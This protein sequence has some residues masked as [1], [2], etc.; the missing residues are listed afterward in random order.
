MILIHLLLYGWLAT[1]CWSVLVTV[2]DTQRYTMLFSSIILKCDYSTSAQL[3]DVAVTWRFKSFCMDPLF[4]YYSAAYQAGLALNQDPSNDCNDRQ[5]EVRIVIQKR[6]QNEAVLGMDYRQRKITMRD[7]ADLVINEVMW[8][9]HGVYYCSVEA[10]GDTAGDPDKEVKL[11]VLHWLTVI[12][13]VLGGLLLLLFISICWCQ[14]CPHC[15]CCYVRC[16][17]CPTKCCCPEEALARHRYMKQAESL[18]PWMVDK[19]M[20][21]GADRNSQNSSYQLNPLLQRDFSLPHNAPM[22]RQQHYPSSNN[23]VLDFLESELKNLNTAQPLLAGAQYSGA[24]HHPSMLSSLGDVGVREVERRVIQLPPI[25]EHIVNSQRPSNSSQQRRNMGSWDPLYSEQD[26]RRNRALDTSYSTESDWRAHDRLRD[27]RPYGHR[28]ETQSSSRPRRDHSPQRRHDYD[29]YSDHSTHGDDRGR[30]HIRTRSAER[31]RSPERGAQRSGRRG[32]P[33]QYSRPREQ[34]RGP[35]P[36]HRRDSWS[37]VDENLHV[38]GRSERPQRSY[39]WPEEKPPSYKSLDVTTG[40]TPRQIVGR[41][42]DRASSRSGR[43]MMI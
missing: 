2:Q 13:I 15:C 39:E 24:S 6:G 42:S 31:R 17:C 27:D 11:V 29:S 7:K 10:Q 23:R 5:R 22:V 12:F 38:R 35:S 33:D 34:R 19:N 30:S 9:D 43:S 4:D 26:R 8:W 41:Q 1:S 3:Q 40:K 37:S 32:S 36:P 20:F 16:P 21:A 25:V 14:C 28:R 18:L